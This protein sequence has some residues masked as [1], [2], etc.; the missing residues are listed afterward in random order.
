MHEVSLDCPDVM[1][2]L[3]PG[4]AT[5]YDAVRNEKHHADKAWSQMLAYWGAATEVPRID[6]SLFGCVGHRESMDA[7]GGLDW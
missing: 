3:L 6:L 1:K 2:S 5:R 4:G 7:W